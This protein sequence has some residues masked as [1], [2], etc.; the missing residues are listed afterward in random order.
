MTESQILKLRP[1]FNFNGML[2]LVDWFEIQ[3]GTGYYT[4]KSGLN[5]ADGE[6]KSPYYY[7]DFAGGKNTKKLCLKR[8][9]KWW[10][11]INKE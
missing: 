5:H 7:Y 1:Q 4:I 6:T 2:P 9:E 8:F 11:E 3:R 10:I